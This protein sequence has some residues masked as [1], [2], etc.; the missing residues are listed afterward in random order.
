MKDFNLFFPE[1]NQKKKSFSNAP[2][3]DWLWTYAY[4]LKKMEDENAKE[5]NDGANEEH[6]NLVSSAVALDLLQHLIF[7]KSLNLHSFKQ[8]FTIWILAVD[9]VIDDRRL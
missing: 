4:S 6:Q 5:P 8:S 2:V 9:H 7:V 3:H 1:K